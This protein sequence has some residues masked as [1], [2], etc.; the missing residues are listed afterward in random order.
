[1]HPLENL[2]DDLADSG[3]EPGA[4]VC[5]LRNGE[6]VVEHHVGTRDGAVPWDVATLV[7]TYSV[8]KPFAALTVLSAVAEGALGLDQRV[9]D[10]WPDY[11]AAGKAATT[12][13]HVLSHSAGLA[14]F[15]EAA[16]GFPYDDRDALVALLAATAPDHEPGAAVA[17]HAL[18]Y[19]HLCDEIVR[20]ATGEDLAARFAR[21]A[22]AHGWD[23]HLRVGAS[24]LDRVADVVAVDP[25]WPTGYLDDP[26]WGPALGRPT[27]L[28]DVDVLN[29]ERFRTTSFPAVA[30][31]ASAR[32]LARFY[33]DLVAEDGAVA[34]LLGPDLHAAYI[35]AAATGHD[36]VLDRE[37]AWTLGFQVDA[38][39]IG[40]G[41]AGGSSAWWSFGGRYAAAYV[42]RGLGTHERSGA[43][44]DALE[45]VGS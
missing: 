38:E 25:T 44:W 22:V 42:T 18:T 43:V 1:M 41:G 23:L 26:R 13:R 10:V 12:V 45:S 6:V 15:P 20:R 37:V 5:V 7:M 35:S 3:A 19:G 40:M 14:C 21:I 28:L 33:A 34:T 9:A 17:E 8:A 2:L 39:D 32:G 29:S 36:R 30:L 16:A 4:A 31:H 11:A 24:D 27:G